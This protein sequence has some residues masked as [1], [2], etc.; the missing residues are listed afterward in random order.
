MPIWEQKGL[1][2]YLGMNVFLNV[3]KQI[4][5]DL[6]NTIWVLENNQLGT[7]AR[8]GSWFSSEHHWANLPTLPGWKQSWGELVLYLWVG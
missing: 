7:Q 2:K 8:L 5:I 1:W 3:N 6:S 4:L